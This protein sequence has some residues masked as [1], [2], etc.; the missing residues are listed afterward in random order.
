MK[1]KTFHP[2]V[3]GLS[4]FLLVVLSMMTGTA[5]AAEDESLRTG[6][7]VETRE[8]N[9]DHV[10]VI[11]TV[12]DYL[13]KM[14]S[15]DTG[16]KLRADFKSGRVYI[17]KV[18]GGANAEV[19]PGVLGAGRSM[20][21]SDLIL[22]QLGSD[23]VKA[24]GANVASWAL[25]IFHEYIHMDQ[26]LPMETSM[27]ETPA[28]AATLRKNGQWIRWT[29][30]KIAPLGA[31]T[32]LTPEE[33]VARLQELRQTLIDLQG[34]LDV[35]LNEMRGKLNTGD[36]DKA[37]KWKGVPPA[38]GGDATGTTNIDILEAYA[39]AQIQAGLQEINR[40]LAEA[41]K[42]PVEE[43]KTVKISDSEEVT[44]YFQGDKLIKRHGLT[45][46]SQSDDTRVEAEYQN[47]KK[48]H[49]KVYNQE[50]NHLIVEKWFRGD[51]EFEYQETTYSWDGKPEFEK[52]R[53]DP[54][55]KWQMKVSTGEWVDN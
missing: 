23:R 39:H 1:N 54:N 34:P 8:L 4:I 22:N 53:L 19:N 14:G 20:A 3:P 33:R 52:R 46:L 42:V 47:D 21:I 38:G 2:F 15:K 29:I 7:K 12:A 30:D 10:K 31:N 6:D 49:S 5:F 43:L 36:L 16:K 26:L 17:G 35:T 48:V 40:L 13:D 27:H 28:W 55:S 11:N 37:Y 45:K 44:G 25:T 50:N 9:P 24:S 32:A 51:D 41:K 18:G